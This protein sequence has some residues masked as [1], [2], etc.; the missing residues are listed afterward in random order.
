MEFE[1]VYGD[2][3]KMKKMPLI[4]KILFVRKY[5]KNLEDMSLIL[6]DELGRRDFANS[7][8]EEKK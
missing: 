3:R 6:R 8:T 4:L 2:Y 7:S 5:R 1:K